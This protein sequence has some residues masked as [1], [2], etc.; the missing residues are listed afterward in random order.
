MKQARYSIL[1]YIFIILG[2]IIT[3]FTAVSA[4]NLTRN[5]N[6]QSQILSNISNLSAIF[7][8]NLD[9][10]QLKK[11]LEVILNTYP[12]IKALHIRHADDQSTF[13]IAEKDYNS[14]IRFN[15]PISPDSLTLPSLTSHVFYNNSVIGEL[16][17]Y[18]QEVH[19]PY[20]YQDM[21]PRSQIQAWIDDLPEIKIGLFDWSPLIILPKDNQS[22]PSGILV[23]LLK[24]LLPV[25]H[26]KLTFVTGSY[27]D[28][29]QKISNDEIDLIPGLYF[30]KSLEQYG[31]F[32]PSLITVKDYL[33]V[34]DA[35][36]KLQNLHD[37][38]NHRI[39]L[40]AQPFLLE[41]L[42]YSL[43]NTHIKSFQTSAEALTAL[44]DG[45]IDAILDTHISMSSELAKNEDVKVKSFHQAS[46]PTQ[47]LHLFTSHSK[48]E[49]SQYI[50]QQ[51]DLLSNDQKYQIIQAY[52]PDLE[53]RNNQGFSYQQIFLLLTLL[54]F[55]TLLA[56]WGSAEYLKK[57]NNSDISL[58]T[59][60]SPIFSKFVIFCLALF[61]TYCTTV[62]WFI[63]S[64]QHKSIESQH[65]KN[66]SLSLKLIEERIAQK[67]DARIKS[68]LALRDF[69]DFRDLVNYSLNVLKSEKADISP[70]NWSNYWQIISVLLEGQSYYVMSLDNQRL[71]GSTHDAENLDVAR[72]YPHLYR[73]LLAG[74]TAIIPPIA[75]FPDNQEHT[76]Y[77]KVRLLIPIL[78][79]QQELHAI[80]VENLELKD[81]FKDILSYHLDSYA[82]NIY[83]IDNQGYFLTTHI[84][85]AE[86]HHHHN[87]QQFIPFQ[88][89]INYLNSILNAPEQARLH[90]YRNHIDLDVLG[91]VYWSDLFDFGFVAEIPATEAFQPYQRLKYS[92]TALILLILFFV[93][94]ILLITLN[95]GRKANK[96]LQNAQTELEQKVLERTIDLSKAEEQGRLILT[97]IGQGLFGLD[98][99]GHVIFINDAA[100][101]MLGFI[102]QDIIGQTILDKIIPDKQES[103]I[104]KAFLKNITYS[105]L[106]TIFL[107]R[108]RHPFPVEYSCRSILDHQQ[109]RGCV[110][111]FS[112][113]RYRKQMSEALEQAKQDAEQASQTKSA[114]LAN[115]SHEIRTPMNSIIGMAH[116]VLETSLSNKQRNYIEKLSQSAH[117]LLKIINDILDFSKNEAGKLAL[118]EIPF[119]LSELMQ[120][121]HQLTVNEAEKKGL[122]FTISIS[123]QIPDILLGDPLRLKQI[124]INLTNNAIK[125]TSQG[126]VSLNI[127]CLDLD[128]LDKTTPNTPPTMNLLFCI[129]DSGIGIDQTQLPHLFTSFSQADS[130]TTRQFGGT[131]LGLAICKQLAQAM[132][133]DI[134]V[135]STSG[136]GSQ[137][138]V[139][140]PFRQA[141]ANIKLPQQPA[142]YQHTDQSDHRRY[143]QQ[144]Q[145]AHILLVEDVD[146]NQEVAR[147]I[148]ETNGILVSLA[149]NG[150]E[151]IE[152]VQHTEFD[153]I[154]MDCHMPLM[155]GYQATQEIRKLPKGNEI[156]ILAM[157]ANAMQEDREKSMQAGMND[158]IDKPI[159][160]PDLFHKLSKWVTPKSAQSS[161][162]TLER[163][164]I[165]KHQS[166]PFDLLNHLDVEAALRLCQQNSDLYVSLLQKFKTQNTPLLHN[167][168]KSDPPVLLA[169]LRHH[170]HILKS[171]SGNIGARALQLTL[172]SLS[173]ML[174]EDQLAE[175]VLNSSEMSDF[176]ITLKQCLTD[177]DHFLSALPEPETISPSEM[178]AGNDKDNSKKMADIIAEMENYLQGSD[179]EALS[180]VEVFN[181]YLSDY[182]HLGNLQQD[183]K[184]ALS[185]YDFETARTLFQDII[186]EIRDKPNE[187]LSN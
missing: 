133:G 9:D 124:L 7:V 125:F 38:I 32:S 79:P 54:F 23:D 112:D 53:N 13:L 36:D 137:F 88:E 187:I 166:Y 98:N 176:M 159:L 11:T 141:E 123:E 165:H 155:D 45:D 87:K 77:N 67:I 104:Q 37:L 95:L 144:L 169:D 71:F 44:Q 109:V 168:A 40:V 66:L 99:Q 59:F 101:N 129:A 35:N 142:D 2:L 24:T 90:Q 171:T 62:S 14:K 162:P 17:L 185:E 151:A 163:Q 152:H 83:P 172:H 148:L 174:S 61:I 27:A 126:H 73:A 39:G 135:K 74:K 41:Y 49:L 31:A 5:T 161:V 33:Y 93:M 22:Q 167:L 92:L 116:L 115:M 150:L 28:L 114:F 110:V 105:D 50:I 10:E 108:E 177:I 132:K 6:N 179:T 60:G 47:S 55:F 186:A 64:Q 3:S 127:T 21:F 111:V 26:F 69:Q 182:P 107:T 48:P 81:T 46:L 128:N 30:Q 75:H 183:L 82:T 63:L 130:S 80:L 18:F 29:L 15:Q 153:A 157:T 138:Y 100:L 70:P 147:E 4:Q 134:W 102:E 57:K 72:L 131:G 89:D 117:F 58:F 19:T 78:S 16:D 25:S 8:Y 91:L 119:R 173:D 106:D 43:P 20:Q 149:N 181:N 51:I 68:L 164:Q 178:L 85:N 1:C 184:Q 154:L 52:T 56:F 180:L 113:I 145:G 118:E 96:K 140:L 143:L 158:H 84:H 120:D 175:T 156:P 121:I 34:S 170:L 12:Q 42:S 136:K 76:H 94:P 146:L 139:S 65:Y 86:Q 160:I 122:L 97:S 103:Q